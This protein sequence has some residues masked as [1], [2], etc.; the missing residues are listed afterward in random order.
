[1][2]FLALWLG[3]LTVAAS[4]AEAA[5]SA[6]TTWI[7]S[8][9]KVHARFTGTTG[10][11]AQFGDSISFTMAFWSPLEGTPKNMSAEAARAHRIVKAHIKPECWQKWKGP[12]YGNN[13]SMTVRWADENVDA[14]LT[15]LNPEAA[16]IMFGS[17]D[18]GQMDMAEYEQKLRRVVQRCLKNGTIVLLT[19]APPRG[20]HVEKS[21]TFAEAARTIAREENVPLIDYFAEIMARRPNDWDGGL[22]QFKGSPGNEYEVPT[23][24]A[25]DGVHP[26]NPK[27]HENDFS[28]EGLSTNGFALRNYLTL[29][30]YAD[31]IE[32]VIQ[33]AQLPR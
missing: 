33:P 11:F 28:N 31:V 18:V 27:K 3:L 4:G 21:R 13:G 2:R 30:C 23:L 10:T 12:A 9:T 8:L 25:R 16:V 20:G 26:S 6:R 17:N 14:W 7:E 32:K 19:T 22:P 1:M 15:K 5:D 24:I 29:M